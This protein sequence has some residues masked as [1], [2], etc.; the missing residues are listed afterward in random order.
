MTEQEAWREIGQAAMAEG[1]DDVM[2]IRQLM[3]LAYAT[4]TAKG[5]WEEERSLGE[6]IALQHSELSEV[7][8]E[9]RNGRD[10]TEVYYEGTKPCG[11]PIEYVDLLLRVFDTCQHYGIDL[12]GAL[13]LKMAYN[14]TRPHRHGGKLA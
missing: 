13:E 12:A 14:A 10:I 3:E 2:D 7:L 8:E 6:Q 11:I 5:W 1:G 9:W 4:A